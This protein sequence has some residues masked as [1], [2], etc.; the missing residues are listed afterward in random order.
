[1]CVTTFNWVPFIAVQ[2]ENQL[3]ILETRLRSVVHYRRH[4][5]LIIGLWCSWEC[6]MTTVQLTYGACIHVPAKSKRVYWLPH[7]VLYKY[8][9]LLSSHLLSNKVQIEP[10][11]SVNTYSTALGSVLS[12]MLPTLPLYLW[13]MVSHVTSQKERGMQWQWP[14]LWL[15]W[16][17]CRHATIYLTFLI[18]VFL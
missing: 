1:M 4:F 9:R 14:L 16:S 10:L 5:Y 12:L 13:L 3:H 8:C 17:P 18:F 11:T 7:M 2:C 15:F 6:K